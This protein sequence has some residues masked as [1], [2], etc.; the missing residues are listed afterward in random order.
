[1][2]ASSRREFVARAATLASFARGVFGKDALT[3][4]NLGVQLYT[5]RNIIEKDPAS[6]LKSIADIGYS[7]IEGTSG[8]LDKI[9]S[10]LQGTSLK[11]VSVH[12][13]TGI[14]N[15][16]GDALTSLLSGLKQ[17]GFQY[18]VYPYVPPNQ[19]GGLD[20]FK[21]L[22]DTLNR[23]GKAAE[24]QGLKFCYHNHAFE[25]E[26]MGG[27]TGLETFMNETSKETVGL[28]LDIFWVVTAGHDPIE[29]LHKYKGRIPL[30]HLKDRA[31]G[32][33]AQYN[34]KVPPATFKE[35]GS[36][37]IDIPAVLKTADT[38]GVK[39]YFVEQDQTPGNPIASLRKSYEYLSKQF[40][41]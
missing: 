18:A 21:K 40:K 15:T 12:V 3:H 31:K 22:A 10:A 2:S 9:W 11:P 17:K 6:V 36:G 26:P 20:V 28:E 35:V 16:G 23:S 13:E 34:E 8:N 19:R 39:H 5:V 7:E 1:M 24:A 14:W 29:L 41:T 38:V 4:A 30:L 27:T 37:S 33:S 25:F 32:S